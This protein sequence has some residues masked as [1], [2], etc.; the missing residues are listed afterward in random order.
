MLRLFLYLLNQKQA[1][2]AL[3]M[4]IHVMCS[5]NSSVDSKHANVPPC[6]CNAESD[7]IDGKTLVDLSTY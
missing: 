7:L 2:A 4:L 3:I 6:F 5:H 1:V